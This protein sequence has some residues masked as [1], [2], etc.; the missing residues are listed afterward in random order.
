VTI[1]CSQI[2][3]NANLFQ[4]GPAF[5]YVVINGIPSNGSMVIIGNG[6]I[7]KQDVDTAL[8]VLPAS[9]YSTKFPTESN[10]ESEDGNKGTGAA[11]GSTGRR[12]GALLTTLVGV[13]GAVA[14]GAGLF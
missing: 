7:G 10:T 3:P 6:K 13:L 12:S 8:F 14:T 1:H 11:M 4:P 5:L 9:S 2:P